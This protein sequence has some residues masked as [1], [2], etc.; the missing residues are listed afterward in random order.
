MSVDP[1][2]SVMAFE[3]LDSRG[4][5][6]VGCTVVTAGGHRGRAIVPSG[7]STGSHEARELRDGG[8]RY[9]GFGVQRA[10]ANAE[11]GL[12]DAVLGLDVVDQAGV[13]IA[14]RA[15][16]GTPDGGRLGANAILAISVATARAAAASRGMPLFASCGE[17]VRST[18]MPMVNI[19]SGGAHAAR[20]LDVQDF[21][22]IPVGATTFSEAIERVSRVR[23]ATGEVLRERGA[24]W[25]LVADEGGY[26]PRLDGNRDALEVLMRA[27]ERTGLTPGDDIAIAIDVAA[28]QFHTSGND[29]YRWETEGRTMTAR[30]LT[31]ELASWVRDFP[32]VSIEDAL[33]EDD[34]T[35]WREATASLGDIQLLGD[36]LFVTSPDRVQRGIDESVANAVLVKPNQIGTLS[37]AREVVELAH[38]A[39]YATVLSARSGET[40][41]DWLA[42]LAVGWNTGQIKVGSTMRSERTA[43]WNRLLEIERELG[44]DI[45][46]A[47]PSFG[48]TV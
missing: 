48:R 6:T 16:D 3:A 18:P 39:G 17:S 43:K 47:Q 28:T 33:A 4:R 7:A 12:R 41:D 40:E 11:G 27:F 44:P 45:A 8:E 37:Q 26:G 24:T 10:V 19:I 34:W 32:I 15:A 31:A 20:A 46:V 35:G 42:D 14:L 38:A 29:T 23:A 25:A 9:G 36:D 13:D 2:A 22:V 21:L 30:E 1:V 5:P